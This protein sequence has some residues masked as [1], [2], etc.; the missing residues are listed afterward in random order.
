LRQLQQTATLVIHNAW[1]VNFNLSLKSFKPNLEGVVNLVNFSLRA[2]YGPH[3]YFISSI[4][5]TMGHHTP[6]GLT[7]EDVVTTT[8]P[9]PNGYA[10]SKYIA[11]RLL[12]EVAERSSGAFHPAYS[13]VGQIAGPVRS[14]G[15]WNRAEWFPS[16]ILSSAH[17]GALPES[18]GPA[19]DRIDWVPID[20]LA[21]VLVDLAL[22]R[23]VRVDEIVE[24]HHPV[25]PSPLSWNDIRPAVVEALKN[26]S[27]ANVEN[28][29][30]REW[31]HRVRQDIE[32]AGV[33]GE[34]ELQELLAQNPAAKLLNF[35]DQ[36]MSQSTMENSLDT[37][38]TTRR[39]R[40]LQ[41]VGAIKAVWIQKWVREWL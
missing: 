4:S 6:N 35:F 31:L 28:V 3:L 10:N 8:V 30:F 23:S 15:L 7:P 26:S 11:E 27:G 36:V 2:T 18:L 14:S 5:S 17:I 24:V 12:A 13:R 34:K 20:L 33:D 39:C 1:A 29:T 16:L 38:L 25:S 41:A 22:T 21:E 40:K 19:L 32:G 9:A 37:Q